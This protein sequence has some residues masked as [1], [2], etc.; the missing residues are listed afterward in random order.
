MPWELGMPNFSAVVV[1]HMNNDLNES[2]IGQ[3]YQIPA[4][5]VTRCAVLPQDGY[6]M[7][8]FYV[9]VIHMYIILFVNSIHTLA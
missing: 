7:V 8:I 2:Q 3:S 6:K 9:W 1:I 4:Q 5:N